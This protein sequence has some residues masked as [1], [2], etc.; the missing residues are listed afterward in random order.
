MLEY[1]PELDQHFVTM[2]LEEPD[3]EQMQEI[4]FQ[5]S[6]Q[7]GK[8]GER[9]SA[10]ALQ[11]TLYLSHRF[12]SRSRM[13][14]KSLD[15]IEQVRATSRKPE[16][17]VADVVERFCENHRVPRNLVDPAI[18]LDLATIRKQFEEQVLGQ[19]EAV[20]VVVDV[21][22]LIKAGMSDSRRPFGVF[23]FVGP[24]GVGKT[25]LAQLLAEFLFG[26]KDR[27]LRINMAD[28]SEQGKGETL[29]GNPNGTS[30]AMTRGVLTQR[31]SGH[32]FAVLL[33][34]EFEKAHESVHD[35]L[36]QLMDEG[37]FING[38]GEFVSCR[39][40]II[41]ATSNAGAEVYRTE[42]F[43]FGPRDVALV[44]KEAELARKL[45]TTFRFEFL[46]RFDQ[47]VHFHP[48]SQSNIR[49]IALRE[50]ELIKQ[51]AGFAHRDLEL[52]VDESL[53]DWIS[54]Q[55][56]HPD[57]GARFLRR[58][59]ERHVAT[60]IA[61]AIVRESPPQGSTLRATVRLDKV[62]C[63][64]AANGELTTPAPYESQPLEI[65]EREAVLDSHALRA[66]ANE[67]LEDGQSLL[68]DFQSNQSERSTLL[69]RMSKNDSCCNQGKCAVLERFRE[70]EVLLRIQKRGVEALERLAEERDNFV[71]TEAGR[72]RL[73]NR[74][75]AAT[76]C[77]GEWRQHQSEK[78]RTSLWL[79]ISCSE[80]SLNKQ[81]EELAGLELSWCER[82]GLDAEVVA[83][84]QSGDAV[85][86]VFLDIEGVGA[87]TFL[88]MEEGIHRFEGESE[89]ALHCECE[90]WEKHDEVVAPPS[91]RSSR[92]RI[93]AFGLQ[94]DCK[95]QVEVMGMEVEIVGKRSRR[96]SK[97]ISALHQRS[98]ATS[99]A[100]NVVRNYQG[101][102]S[103]SDPRT[104]V[105]IERYGDIM[106]GNLDRFLE[107]WRQLP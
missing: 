31:V 98:K 99:K 43:G 13:P 67:V 26:D 91:I 6:E 61:A 41:I 7:R 28:Y 16:V 71:D 24:T 97:L 5:W 12:L 57:F 59:I 68:D 78:N 21:V 38:A 74:V 44:E 4:L 62:V 93:G 45:R 64:L 84:G 58:T 46:N 54:V 29:F 89:V 37:S 1:H 105:K 42:S 17:D 96:F 19:P 18:R 83:Y 20:R 70:I 76:L 94:V 50:L 49:T 100:Q 79:M 36:L 52:V 106:A 51:R 34:D 81:V 88:R 55:G 48:L 103:V 75:S 2:V 32:P 11:Q 101:T 69:R 30:P 9:F 90:L 72:W 63:Y 77:L 3:L 85:S 73:H 35:R 23:L 14:R 53:V 87:H 10:G 107:A 95:S 27:L 47:I 60:A 102:N 82:L 56:Y 40:L 39:S 15:L 22:G 66:R 25:H 86:H 104:G 80:P 65:I 92:S 33:L 8:K